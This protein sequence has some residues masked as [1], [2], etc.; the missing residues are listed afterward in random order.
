MLSLA[1]AGPHD[2]SYIGITNAEHDGASRFK[3][4]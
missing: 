2:G 1:E 3:D 4:I